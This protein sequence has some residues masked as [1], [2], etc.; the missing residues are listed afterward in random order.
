MGISEVETLDTAR[1]GT[2]VAYELIQRDPS[3]N[4]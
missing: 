4:S 1:Y 2:D 3:N